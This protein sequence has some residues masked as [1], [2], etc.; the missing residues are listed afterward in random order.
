MRIW[1]SSAR[2]LGI[3]YEGT[4]LRYTFSA[5]GRPIQT[6]DDPISLATTCNEDECK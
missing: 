4:V 5:G 2:Q 1:G 6:V 3:Q